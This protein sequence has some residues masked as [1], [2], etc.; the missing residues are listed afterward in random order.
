MMPDIAVA[1][2]DDRYIAATGLR[3]GLIN[4]PAS[5]TAQRHLGTADISFQSCTSMTI[6]C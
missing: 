2:S 4:D 1:M 5:T 3:G 6:A